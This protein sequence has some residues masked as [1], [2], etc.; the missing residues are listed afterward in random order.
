MSQLSQFFAARIP[1]PFRPGPFRPGHYSETA[2]SKASHLVAQYWARRARGIGASNAIAAVLR[3]APVYRKGGRYESPWARGGVAGRPF[4]KPGR[5]YMPE[6]LRWIESTDAIGLRFIG[7][8]DELPGGPS[9]TGWYCSAD[10]WGGD[11]LRGG[12]WHWPGGRVVY[13]YSEWEGGQETNPGSACLVVS[14]IVQTDASDI[15]EMDSPRDWDSVRCAASWADSMAEKVAESAREYDSAYQTGRRA[16]E[17][18]AQVNELR[19]L[20]LEL[21]A[22]MREERKAAQV[23]RPA[24]CRALRERLDSILATIREAREERESA[25]RDCPSYLES[26]WRDGYSEELGRKSW[27]SFARSL[28]INRFNGEAGNGIL[29]DSARA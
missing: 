16:A 7:W 15:R 25:W 12:V 17:T 22:E 6:T 9:H 14:D 3:L 26:A 1:G 23:E 8:A 28:S 18:I 2:E 5:G 19:P 10:E 27:N 4:L 21:L 11:T 20:A 13:G 29:S 24:I